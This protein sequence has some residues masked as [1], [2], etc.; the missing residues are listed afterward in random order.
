MAILSVSDPERASG[1]GSVRQRFGAT[2]SG[3]DAGKEKT[4]P[5]DPDRFY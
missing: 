5:D 1:Y 3:P 4:G 2:A